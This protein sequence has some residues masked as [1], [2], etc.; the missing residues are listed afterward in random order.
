MGHGWTRA[1]L[2]SARVGR[3]ICTNS[4]C[5]LE[6]YGGGSRLHTSLKVHDI[7]YEHITKMRLSTADCRLYPYLASEGFAPDSHR[8]SALDPT[9]GLPSPNPLSPPYLQTLATPLCSVDR[10]RHVKNVKSQVCDR[11]EVSH[12]PAESRWTVGSSCRRLRWS[13]EMLSSWRSTLD[14]SLHLSKRPCSVCVW[15]SNMYC[16][17]SDKKA[18]LSQRWPRAMCRQK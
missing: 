11:A 5:F 15:S 7:F 1:H 14:G 13:V 12:S 8:G 4:R 16:N 2:T 18:V 9:G 10:Q 3:E 6:Q 17:V